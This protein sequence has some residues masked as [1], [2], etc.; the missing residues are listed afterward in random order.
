MTHP[1]LRALAATAVA[2]AWV[3]LTPGAASADNCDI[4]INPEDCQNTGWAIGTTAAVSGI[5]VVAT[6]A[7]VSRRAGG[8]GRPGTSGPPNPGGG[9]GGANTGTGTG[10]DTGA[11]AGLLDFRLDTS[12]VDDIS[13]VIGL[14]AA[15]SAGIAAGRPPSAAVVHVVRDFRDCAEAAHWVRRGEEAGAAESRFTATVGRPARS[16]DDRTGHTASVE[17]SWAFDPRRSGITLTAPRWPG[18]TA[19][20]RAAVQRYLDALRG[21]EE[22]H[23]RVAREYMA[24]AGGRV[25]GTGVTPGAAAHDLQERLNALGA[26]TRLGLAEA[27]R[28][29][30]LRTDHGRA[31]SAV[32]GPDVRLECP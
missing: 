12:A 9:D 8:S 1:C 18:M 16:G 22:G 6:A 11:G 10:A 23:H 17:V 20:D 19:A 2:A 7:A 27:G 4:F 28:D 31:Q 25:T 32:G 26:R 13:L 29:Y 24:S 3:L 21:H 14:V 30:D 5:A 15:R